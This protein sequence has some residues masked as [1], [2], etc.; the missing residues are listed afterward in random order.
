M[1][2]DNP[3]DRALTFLSKHWHQIDFVE[4]KDWCEA[5]DLDTPV[6]EGLCD[7]YAV[8]D[9]I[10]T[11]GYEGC[12]LIEQ[13]GNAGLQEG[14]TPLECARASRDFIRRALGV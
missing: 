13:N 12:L 9:L 3:A 6:S 1:E 8:F 4:F 7:Y 5:T 11:G 2:V 10:K 14:R